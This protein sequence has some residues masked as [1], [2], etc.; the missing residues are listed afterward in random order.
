MGRRCLCRFPLRVAPDSDKK[1]PL[2]RVQDPYP[3]A[4][5]GG[6]EPRKTEQMADHPQNCMCDACMKACERR[7]GFW[8]DGDPPPRGITLDDVAKQEPIFMAKVVREMTRL[9]TLET[10]AKNRRK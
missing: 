9:A 4:R 8:R 7:F 5:G 6:A 2:R 1:R 10:A 3:G